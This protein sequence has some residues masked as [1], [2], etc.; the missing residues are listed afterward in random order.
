MLETSHWIEGKDRV[1]PEVQGS[2][3][4][5]L[6]QFFLRYPIFLLV[7]GPPE[8][9]ASV[10]GV[11]TSQAHFD[12]WNVLQVGWLTIVAVRAIGRLSTARSV[13]IPK[14][15]RSIL[16]LFLFL[17]LVFLASVAYSP[18]RV[19][20]LEFVII[21]SLTM[22][23][24]VEFVADAYRNP[25]NWLQCIFQLRFTSLLLLVAVVLTIP[26]APTLV[27][28]V[29]PGVGI[30]LLGG[31]V[32]PMGVCPSIVAIVSAYTFLNSL[33]SRV[34]SALFFLVGLA[35]TLVTQARGAELSLFLVLAVLVLSWARTNRKTAYML[36]SISMAAILL[37]GATIG[38]IGGD[39]IWKRFNRGEDTE[40]IV[41]ASGRTVIW[42]E[43][44]EDCLTH[45]QGLGYIAGIRQTHRVGSATSMHDLLHRN[46]GVDNSFI[47]IL[48]SAGWLALALYLIILAK[49]IVLGMRSLKKLVYLSPSSAIEF[50]HSLHCALL[51]L[52]FCLAEGMESS[53][54]ATPLQEPFYL[55]I[56]LIAMILGASGSV[57]IEFRPRHP[58]LAR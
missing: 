24:M 23:C 28:F 14:Q 42:T 17:G 36:V 18:G 15:S 21:Y 10:T 3:F 11:E 57:L 26:F 33:E 30:R 19:I 41:T 50:R 49:T 20:S 29:F 56:V 31:S 6:L 35:G 8:F 47:E 16:R 12:L 4:L 55:Q 25:P 44:I 38:T 53:G 52:M 58:S 43:I 46:G 5:P 39:R 32:A 7:F 54:F 40:G 34:R 13:L 2:R 27:M 51:L 1:L 48:G 9:K 22:I 37:A 45:P